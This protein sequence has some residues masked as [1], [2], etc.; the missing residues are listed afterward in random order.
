MLHTVPTTIEPEVVTEIVTELVTETEKSVETVTRIE[1]V[2][3]IT[4]H[5]SV[6]PDPDPEARIVPETENEN[7]LRPGIVLDDVPPIV[8]ILKTKPEAEL[9]KPEANCFAA[10]LMGLKC[11]DNP[12]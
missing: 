3:E 2:T 1:S 12:G 10:I 11:G 8:S 4:S 7:K 6:G 5:T 9:P